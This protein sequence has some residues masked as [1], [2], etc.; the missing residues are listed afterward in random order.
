MS[1]TPVPA[2]PPTG[3][4]P[5]HAGR[6]SSESLQSGYRPA[7]AGRA[8]CMPGEPGVPGLRKETREQTKPGTSKGDRERDGSHGGTEVMVTG[9]EARHGEE[10]KRVTPP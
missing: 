1:R 6:G 3:T 5:M 7:D 4:L 2:S 10:T 8:D 9:I